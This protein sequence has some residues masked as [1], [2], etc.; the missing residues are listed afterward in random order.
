MYGLGYEYTDPS[1]V[2][3]ASSHDIPDRIWEGCP[4]PGDSRGLVSEGSVG[5]LYIL[6]L[7][8]TVEIALWCHLFLPLNTII[9]IFSIALFP[10]PSSFLSLGSE[11]PL[12]H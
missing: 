12:V 9:L 11:Y 4:G 7:A 1:F 5:L 3:E 8:N 2:R 6:F 10:L